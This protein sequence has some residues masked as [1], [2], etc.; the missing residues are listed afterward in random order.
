MVCT[1]PTI[2]AGPAFEG[3]IRSGP[4]ACKRRHQSKSL[5]SR[6]WWLGIYRPILDNPLMSVPIHC[7]DFVIHPGFLDRAAQE[8]LVA[9]L[10]EVLRK[11]PLFTP[12]TRRGPMSVRMSAAGRFGWIS[13]SRGYRYHEQHPEGM[14][15]PA[16]PDEVLA[17]WNSL[18]GCARTPECCLINWYGEGAKM[19]MHRDADETDYSCPVVSVSLGDEGLFRMGNPERGGPTE[20][21]RLQSGDVVVMGGG[22]RRAH[23]GV[24]RIMF[25]SSTLLPKGGRINLTLRVVT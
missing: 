20:S 17:I 4:R 3:H 10:R 2:A 15:W 25:G 7:K 11:A 18:S 19:G 14:Q 22:A 12:T 6:F 5:V 16:I 13:D 24:D 9:R 21:I 8:I 23:H 1:K